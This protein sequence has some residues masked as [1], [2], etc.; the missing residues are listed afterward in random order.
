MDYDTFKHVM[1]L[2]DKGT[3]H[4]YERFYYPL[5]C[6]MFDKPV[7]LLEIGVENGNSMK[8]W[9]RLFKNA[10]HLYGIGYKN[11]QQNYKEV[12]A[13]NMTL[14][15]GDQSDTKFLNNFVQDSGG[16]FDFVID[17][18][19]HV[20]S[21]IVKS[22]DYLW[23]QVNPGGYYI[24][25]D[26]ET[27]YWRKDTGLYGYSFKH[28]GSTV[29]YFKNKIDE[30]NNEFRGQPSIDIACVSFVQNMIIIQK[31]DKRHAPYMNRKYR[32]SHFT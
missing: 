20:P 10:N 1:D 26:I 2:S 7:R 27:S 14:F 19:S 5:F 18:G 29:D 4:G 17:D 11:Y 6:D 3:H 28:E 12:V 31:T 15:M 21:H 23:D 32:F 25:E 9:D 13:N 8:I 16:N 30:I 24:I 22:F